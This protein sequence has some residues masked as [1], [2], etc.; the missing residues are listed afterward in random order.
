MATMV[1]SGLTRPGSPVVPPDNLVE[2]AAAARQLR[3]GPLTHRR[4]AHG[5]GADGSIPPRHAQGVH[6]GLLPL[7]NAEEQGTQAEVDRGEQNQ[8][9]AEAGV[10]VPVRHGPAALP[11]QT[12]AC[13][14]YL[15]GRSARDRPACRRTGGSPQ[16]LRVSGVDSDSPRQSG[17]L[18]V[19]QNRRRGPGSVS[20]TKAKPW[21]Y[22]PTECEWHSRAAARPAGGRQARPRNPAPCAR[23][24]TTS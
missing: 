11:H 16:E 18:V 19:S 3:H 14:P 9:D 8:H 4:V 17:P 7:E 23:L 22:L 21:L 1:R 24:S 2:A 13:E 10:D 6:E 15:A 5:D 12:E 20:T